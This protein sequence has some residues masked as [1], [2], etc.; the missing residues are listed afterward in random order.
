MIFSRTYRYKSSKNVDDIK[1][2]LVGKH[3]KVHNLDF[4]VYE[5]D[6]VIRIIPHAEQEN[7]IRTLPITHVELKGSGDK[8]QVVINSKMRKIDSGGPMLIMIFCTFMLV[9]AVLFFVFGQSEYMT[10]TYTMLGISLAI[11]LV[12]WMR[13]EAGYFDYVRKIRDYIKKQSV[14]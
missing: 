5:N 12:F 4:E 10:F 8:T 14:A 11:F 1:R 3:V 7:T 6:E 2:S 9:G 13:M